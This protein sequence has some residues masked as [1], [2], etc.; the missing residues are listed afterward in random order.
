MS[1]RRRPAWPLRSRRP[2]VRAYTT[3]CWLG[4]SRR[5]WNHWQPFRTV[6]SKVTSLVAAD[7]DDVLADCFLGP[8]GKQAPLWLLNTQGAYQQ[9][10]ARAQ[11]IISTVEASDSPI[12]PTAGISTS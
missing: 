9:P 5:P 7:M 2:A 11:M 10:I 4:G 6:H 12:E 1:I 3:A 8:I